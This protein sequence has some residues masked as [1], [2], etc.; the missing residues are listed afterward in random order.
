MY[1]NIHFKMTLY[2]VWA[3][4]TD[5]DESVIPLSQLITVFGIRGISDL[6]NDGPINVFSN[7][8]GRDPPT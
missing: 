4:K 6:I 8:W 5:T 7:Y 2:P 3:C 1:K